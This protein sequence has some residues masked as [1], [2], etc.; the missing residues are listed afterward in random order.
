M[1]ADYVLANPNGITVK[2]GG[3]INVSRAT[4]AAARPEVNGGRLEALGFG[5]NTA[6]KLDVQGKLGG[7]VPFWTWLPPKLRLMPMP[8][9]KP[10]ITSTWLPAPAKPF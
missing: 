5:G 1:A 7:A 10:Q 4:L 8:T 3:F 2:D 6:A 9:W